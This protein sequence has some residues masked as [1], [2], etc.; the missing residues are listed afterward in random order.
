MLQKSYHIPLLRE[1][2]YLDHPHFSEKLIE[3]YVIYGFHKTA[4]VSDG[5]K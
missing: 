2:L 5:L 4:P 3:I 1:R